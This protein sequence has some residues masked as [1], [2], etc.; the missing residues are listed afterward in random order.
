M[1]QIPERQPSFSPQ[2][3]LMDMP[4]YQ[5]LSNLYAGADHTASD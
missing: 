3:V 5:L 4:V 1:L 2:S